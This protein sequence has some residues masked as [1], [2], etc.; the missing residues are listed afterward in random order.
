MATLS[1]DMELAH[2]KGQMLRRR[3]LAQALAALKPQCEPVSMEESQESLAMNI[4]LL[5]E[6][7]RDLRL[8]LERSEDELRALRSGG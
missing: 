8:E 3:Q 4:R 6:K 2:S 7:V 1:L 5:E